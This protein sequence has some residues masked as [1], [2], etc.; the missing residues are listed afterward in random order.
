MESSGRT[1]YGGFPGC[2]QITG[3]SVQ[4]W[5]K[6]EGGSGGGFPGEKV[7]KSEVK[8]KSEEFPG[9][10]SEKR[11]EEPESGP[12]RL[13]FAPFLGQVRDFSDRF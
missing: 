5:E 4:A 8:V 11:V 9:F 12:F 2:R 3:R 7:Q 10:R 1:G 13:L 6:R